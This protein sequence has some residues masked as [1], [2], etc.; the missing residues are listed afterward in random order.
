MRKSTLSMPLL[1]LSLILIYCSINSAS[2]AQLPEKLLNMPIH[3]IDGKTVRLADYQGIKPVYLKFWATW[4]QPCRKEM[5]HFEHV[6]QTLGKDMAVIGINLGVNDNLQSVQELIK[7]F[8]L[9]MP[10][11]VDRNGDLAQAFRLLG[12]P[13]HLLFDKNMNLIFRGNA[14]DESLDNKLQLAAKTQPIDLL[15][16]QLLEEQSENVKINLQD[17]KLHVLFFSATWCD[18]YLKDSRPQVSKNCIHA[19]KIVNQLADEFSQVQWHGLISRLWTGEKDLQE[20]QKKYAIS[21]PINI[22]YSNRL[23]HEYGINHLPTMVII[24]QGKVLMK[25]TEFKDL[26]AI[27]SKLA[28]QAK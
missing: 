9:T 18:W 5:P 8:N 26:K 23:F 16:A 27:K 25:T 7:E 24:Q 19:Q 3:L 15:D 22:D 21:Y 17:D 14:V 2:A 20:Y 6:Q 12:T 1:I 4:C 13:Y 11:A 10:T 28:L